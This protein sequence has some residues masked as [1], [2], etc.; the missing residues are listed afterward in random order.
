MDSR[1]ADQYRDRVVAVLEGLRTSLYPNCRLEEFVESAPPERET[2]G[3]A[4]TLDTTDGTG[5]S[6]LNIYVY[7]TIETDKNDYP[8]RFV[9]QDDAGQVEMTAKHELSKE[10]LVAA[11]KRLHRKKEGPAWEI[12]RWLGH[13]SDT[14][15]DEV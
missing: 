11:L 4:I 5:R 10:S 8:L 14:Y 12:W 9:C 2:P 7:V 13:L 6:V 1:I 3:W 15:G